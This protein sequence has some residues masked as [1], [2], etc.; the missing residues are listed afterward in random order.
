MDKGARLKNF[1]NFFF[2]LLQVEHVRFQI[3]IAFWEDSTN[4]FQR[5]EFAGR[6]TVIVVVRVGRR[7]L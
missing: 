5:G 6:L 2:F 7:A 3:L 4:A 1:D